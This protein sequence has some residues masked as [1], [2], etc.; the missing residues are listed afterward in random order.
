[1]AV[2]DSIPNTLTIRNPVTDDILGTVTHHTPEDVIEAVARIRKAQPAWAESP[3]RDRAR[4]MKRFHDMIIDDRETLFDLLQ[5]ETGRSRRDAFV[6]LF[7]VA[8]EARYYSTHGKRFLKSR[9]TRSAI[10]FRDVTK[11]IYKPRGV[12]GIISPWNFPLHIDNG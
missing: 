7:A 2:I 10:P 12:I 8:S 11:V 9:R 6:E 3:F 5:A 1:M 4:V